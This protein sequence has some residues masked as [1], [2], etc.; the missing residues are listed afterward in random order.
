MEQDAINETAADKQRAEANCAKQ[1][2]QE[3]DAG[4]NILVKRSWPKRGCTPRRVS[5]TCVQSW[6]M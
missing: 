6:I 5:N 3:F 2:N 1:V 4:E